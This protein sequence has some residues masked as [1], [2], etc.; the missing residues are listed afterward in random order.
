MTFVSAIEPVLPGETTPE[1]EDHAYALVAEA[2]A[3]AGQLNPLVRQSV[4]DLVRSMNCYYSNL[5]EG[6]NTL[7]RDI[8]RALQK[9]YSAEP[10]KRNLQLEAVAHIELQRRIDSGDDEKADAASVKYL[11]WLHREFCSRLPEELLFVENPDMGERLRVSPGD[12]RTRAVKVGLH[13]P[14]EGQDLKACLARFE[15]AY[16]APMGKFRK[17]IAIAASHHRLLWIHP[18]L[19]GNGRVARLMA[20]AMFN[21]LGIGSSLWS[22]SRGLARNVAEYKALLMAADRQRD[23]DYDGRGNLSERALIAFCDFFLRIS[24]DQV[25]FMESILDPANLLRRIELYCRDEVEAGRLPK[26]SY[27]VL[28]EAVLSGEVERGRVPG[29]VNLQER[30]A[31]NITSVLLAKRLLLSASPKAP[32][33]LGF[34]SEVADRWFPSLYPATDH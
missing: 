5:I 8:E 3:L 24:I 2:S 10:Q 30:A 23:N 25:R 29:L 1:L 12:I 16:S 33:R 13:V 28:R 26:L 20:H 27:P 19:D 18:F 15:E 7:P 4:G 31:R 14:P 21:R 6:H 22:V 17:I 34:P 32:L 11:R 9:E